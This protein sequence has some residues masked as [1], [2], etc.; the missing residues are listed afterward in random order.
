A[1]WFQAA[2]HG[3]FLKSATLDGTYV[4][5]PWFDEEVAKVTDGDGLVLGFT[6]PIRDAQGHIIGL[7]HNRANFS[8]V[9]EIVHAA[10]AGLKARGF[11]GTEITLLDGQ[12]RVL[13]D[14][15]PQQQGSDKV[16]R[17]RQVVLALNLA[18]QGTEAAR[19]AVA[20]GRGVVRSLHAGSH[21]EQICAYSMSDG[22]LGFPGLKWSTLVRIPVVEADAIALDTR[23]TL[24]LVSA[25]SLL[26]LAGTALWLGR[27]LSRPILLALERIRLGGDEI[28]GNAR[29]VS[30]SAQSL[31]EGASTQAASLE[32]TAASLE[33]MSSMTKRNADSSRQAQAVAAQARQAA[34]Q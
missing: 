30:G 1:D 11:P 2:L 32:E 14:Y 19:L 3:R 20:G 18:E 31:A 34:D 15:D 6:A 12:G 24:L 10:Y 27:S 4:T 7:W 28:T 17:N 8:F 16:V 25:V 33:E 26:V 13:V 21:V 5:A 23:R 29:Q 22:A 9:E